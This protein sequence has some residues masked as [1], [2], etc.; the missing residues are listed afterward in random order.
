[1]STVQRDPVFMETNFDVN[2]FKVKEDDSFNVLWHFVSQ[3]LKRNSTKFYFAFIK[4]HDWY[5][6]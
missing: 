6:H 2:K 4:L 5:N 1:M 3:W